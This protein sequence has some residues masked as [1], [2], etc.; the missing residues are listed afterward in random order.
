MYLIVG[1]LQVNENH[2]HV[3]LFLLVSLHKL[4]RPSTWSKR[5]G[6]RG[7]LTSTRDWRWPN[8][9]PSPTRNRPRTLMRRTRPHQLLSEGRCACVGI[10]LLV[11]KS[12]QDQNLSSS[13]SWW[14]EFIT[15]VIT[16][17]M[18]VSNL[19]VYP[20]N[21]SVVEWVASP[22]VSDPTPYR[23][24]WEIRVSHFNKICPSCGEIWRRQIAIVCVVVGISRKIPLFAQ[25][26][27]RRSTACPLAPLTAA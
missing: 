25:I 14:T 5:C 23:S 15:K 24:V 22:L 16:V 10:E 7:E 20:C 8:K 4:S 3:L 1:L 2:M 27:Q 21:A 12:Y 6:Q 19:D 13:F 18:I 26:S 17:M 9:E 11:T